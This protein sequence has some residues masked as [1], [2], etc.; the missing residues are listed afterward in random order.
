M[1]NYLFYFFYSYYDRTEKW[2]EAKVPFLSSVL[3]ISVL[4]MFNFLF[5]RD[6]ITYHLNGYKYQYFEYENLIVP[7]IFIGLNYWY[8]KKNDRF[9][10]ILNDHKNITN[11][12]NQKFYLAWT[13]MILSVVLVILM[14]YSVRN[15]IRWI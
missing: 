6:F 13:Y 2:K 8:F 12:K 4:L 1:Y 10:K 15:N 14:G 3:V 7:T 11:K 9:K 5:I